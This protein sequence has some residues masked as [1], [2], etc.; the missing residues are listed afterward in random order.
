[1]LTQRIANNEWAYRSVQSLFRE[2]CKAHP[3]RPAIRFHGQE[4]SYQ[5]LRQQTDQLTQSLLETG[6][7]QGDV[8]SVLPVPTPDFMVVCLAILQT[9]AT[10]NP[11]NLMWDATHFSVV[12]ERNAPRLIF[13]TGEFNG[14][15]YVEVLQHAFSR[16]STGNPPERVVVLDEDL[17]LPDGFTRYSTFANP[18]ATPDIQRIES[19]VENFDPQDTQFICQTSGSTGYSKSAVWNH[20]TPLSTANFG[21]AAVGLDEEDRWFNMTPVFHNSGLCLT[22]VMCL[23]Y[24]GN[25]VYLAEKF[26]PDEAVKTI[27]DEQIAGAAGFAAHWH[28]MRESKNYDASKFR[29]NKPILAGDANLYAYAEEMCP[30]GTLI[31][32]VYAQTENGPIVTMAE[33]GCVDHALRRSNNGRPLPG[34]QIKIRDID[35]GQQLPDAASGEICYKSPY[36]FQGYLDGE[37]NISLPLDEE[38]FFA[39]GDYGYMRNGYLTMIERLGSVVKS[40]GENVA[41]ATVTGR[42]N[43][44]F[45]DQFDNI[46]AIAVPDDYWGD[47]V[48]A[49]VNGGKPSEWTSRQLRDEAKAVLAEYEAPQ[50]FIGWDGPWPTSPEGKLDIKALKQFAIEQLGV[51]KQ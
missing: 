24:I 30:A 51:E 26:L 44:L 18:Q 11:L 33:H 48:V 47:R 42:L 16:Y 20:R 38:G 27:Q 43:D 22:V 6:I 8:V 34:V 5:Q 12:A 46:E 29:L 35:T 32:M 23:S 31:G 49:L 37:G 21:A 36:L 39:S 19:L 45:G 40:G 14:R 10:L 9:G 4:I 50:N 2:T 3:H 1:M 41:L 28:A 13:T 7:S 15:D 25:T 17:A